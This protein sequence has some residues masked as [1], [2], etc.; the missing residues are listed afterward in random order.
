MVQIAR[1]PELSVRIGEYAIPDAFV[2]TS[3]T[4]AA[5]RVDKA[6]S[7]YDHFSMN[8][9]ARTCILSPCTSQLHKEDALSADYDRE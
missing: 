9:G 3:V 6:R 8:A 2:S 4:D 7:V 1:G 5:F